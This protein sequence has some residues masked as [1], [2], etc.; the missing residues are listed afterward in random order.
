MNEEIN[1]KYTGLEVAVIGLSGRFPGANDVQEFWHNLLEGKELIKFFTKEE[2]II[3]GLSSLEIEDEK[4]VPAYGEMDGADNFDAAFF[5]YLPDEARLMDPQIR[6]YHQCVWHALEDSGYNPESFSGRIG[7]F[8]GAS[9][10]VIWRAYAL[11]AASSSG[12]NNFLKD[13]LSNR[14]FLS[15][16]ISY[17]LNLKGPS[18]NVS[19]A[20]STSLVAIHTAIRSLLTGE[21]EMAVAGGVSFFST[22]KKG[23][24][25]E[26]GMINSADGHC[27]TF[28]EKS[29]G[30]VSGD[31]AGAVVLKKL[32]D[33]IKDNDNIYAVVKGSAVNNDG[34]RKVGYSSPSVEG[35]MECIKLAHKVSRVSTDT[36]SYIEAHGTATSL[37]DAIEIEALNNVFKNCERRSCGIGSVKT[38]IGHLDAAAGVAG[39]IKVVLSLNNRQIPRSLHF[40]RANR[41]INFDA[42]PFYVINELKEWETKNEIP[43]RAGISS[44]GIG[45]TNAHVVLEEAPRFNRASSTLPYNL[46]TI[47]SKNEKSLDQLVSQFE[48]YLLKSSESLINIAYTLNCGR[49]DFV[50]RKSLIISDLDSFKKSVGVKQP[51][52]YSKS[53]YDGEFNPIIFMFSG[54]GGQYLN[55]SKELYESSNE[56]K[57]IMDNGFDI[58]KDISKGKDFKKIL[59]NDDDSVDLLLSRTDNTQPLLFLVE[60]SLARYLIELGIEPNY[61]IGHSLGEYVGACISDVFSFE[62]GLFMLYHR[63][64]LMN[65]LPEGDMLSAVISENRAKAF[66]SNDIDLA[67]VN[68]DDQCVFSGSKESI[69]ELNFKFEELGIICKIIE[70][71]HAFHS[72]LM[73][74]MLNEFDDICKRVCFNPPKYKIVSNI[75]GEVISDGKFNNHTYWRDHIISPVRFNEG[76]NAFFADDKSKIFLEIGPGN[77][78]LNLVSQR[79]RH[80]GLIKAKI[81]SLPSKKSTSSSCLIFVRLLK[82]LWH[83]GKQIDWEY[84][85]KDK[86]VFK[87]SLPKYP[88]LKN[89][90][91]A[92]VDLDSKINELV[93]D[94][95]KKE[96]VLESFY[97]QTWTKVIYPECNINYL[98]DSVYVLFGV[99][100]P[101]FHEIRKLLKIQEVPFVEISLGDKFKKAS[102]FE[103]QIRG[104]DVKEMLSLFNSLKRDNISFTKII[105]GWGLNDNEDVGLF[106]DDIISQNS[107]KSFDFHRILNLLK[108]LENEIVDRTMK[109]VYLS[110]AF[111]QVL[112]GEKSNYKYATSLGLLKSFAIE[113]T[114]VKICSVDMD[115]NDVYAQNVLNELQK[116]E[117]NSNIAYRNKARWVEG[118][119]KI[120]LKSNFKPSIDIVKRGGVYIITGGLG[121]VG[122]VFCEYLV[123]EY[124]ATV[125]LLG[126]DILPES[127]EWNRLI[128]AS[129]ISPKIKMKLRFLVDMRNRRYRVKYY[130]VDIS[131]FESFSS[132]IRHTQEKYG[133]INGVI[134]TAGVTNTEESFKSIASTDL[135]FL[136]PHFKSKA[137]GLLNLYDIFKSSGVDF[138]WTTTS[139]STVVGLHSLGAYIA[140][141]LFASHF[142]SSL[143]EAEPNWK[144]IDL[145]GLELKGGPSNYKIS[146]DDLIKIFNISFSIKEK[147]RLIVSM[148]DLHSKLELRDRAIRS[149]EEF[150]F[151]S[152]EGETGDRS[153]FRSGDIE[154][155]S[156]TEERLLALWKKF[157]GTNEIGIEDNFFDLG[158]D[159][160]KSMV[161]V[162]RMFKEFNVDIPLRD[163]MEKATI[164]ELSREI[165]LVIELKEISNPNRIGKDDSDGLII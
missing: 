33:A 163:F 70:T 118:Y 65:E 122:R 96:S 24:F 83:L 150:D 11:L 90:F 147:S 51:I 9:E 153:S 152:H 49:K 30:T 121:N 129:S 1:N 98:D 34:L 94:V 47:S 32:K 23:Y 142:I 110:N 139:L 138:V 136:L 127:S 103:Y 141:N 21:C 76:M 29:S 107:F 81:P 108:C 62:D 37:G 66:I 17:K 85:Y 116:E 112:P 88:F 82:S 4:F 117:F 41:N 44:F 60:Y 109:L 2:L 69:A 149:I 36:I 48:S 73:E 146:R 79:D 123:K 162:K 71:S 84:Y 12:A 58:L 59:F 6:I 13:Q 5:N 140:S 115:S 53:I 15:T 131:D 134:H 54:Q 119:R 61:I 161:M 78:L 91:L 14:D 22:I 18:I 55:M 77:T 45:G 102:K 133:R 97:Q 148:T 39:F 130:H 74:P 35:Q 43:L 144:A 106:G 101:I 132:F 10:N 86:Q 80:E 113:N 63:G 105:Y 99:E 3:K 160:L 124:S 92:E 42:G 67:A 57:K 95:P 68:S 27:R 125:I 158:G 165:D 52:S 151:V 120:V 135:K 104:K 143:E 64:R 111:Q 56:F 20:C 46:I 72:T 114:R 154:P 164:R 128:D 93:S 38:N 137:F 40:E 26:E 31:G 126:R 157:F 156:E 16:L 75:S 7:L 87:L 89:K 159:S 50:F 8:S 25:F 155:K 145:D 100:Q 28:D 19:T